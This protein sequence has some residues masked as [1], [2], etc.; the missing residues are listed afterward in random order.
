MLTNIDN[1]GPPLSL[2]PASQRVTYLYHLGRLWYNCNHF[3]RAQA[4]FS[5]AYLQCPPSFLSHRRL[6][7]SYWI[8]TNLLLGRFPSAQLL[9]RPEAAGLG[10]IFLPICRAIKTGDFVA[11]YDAMEN[12]RP[13]LEA[14]G[15]Y[16]AL[17][18]N[19]KT[20]VWR[21]LTRRTFLLTYTPGQGTTKKAPVLD[22]EDVMTVATYV[23]RRL[24]GWIPA[25][26]HPGQRTNGQTNSMFMRAVANSADASLRATTLVPPPAGKVRELPLDGGLILGNEPVT[27][28]NI[29]GIVVGLVAMGLLNGFVSYSQNKFAVEGTKRA[30]GNPVAAGWP[31]VWKVGLERLSEGPDGESVDLRRVP[32]WVR[33]ANGR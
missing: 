27:L 4:C 20:L 33:D 23:Q 13:W 10:E 18:E 8:P 2:Y 31:E 9:S 28:E 16:W 29:R 12:A 26:R 7:L 21:S 1:I 3:M 6:I 22:L 15:V 25:P 11:Y 32:A 19:G 17:F 30:G 5:E 14:K 24:E